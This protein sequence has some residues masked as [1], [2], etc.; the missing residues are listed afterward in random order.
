MKKEINFVD[1]FKIFDYC[2]NCL[3]RLSKEK[4]KDDPYP[5]H[6]YMSKIPNTNI[7]VSFSISI[8]K[9][10]IYLTEV[11]YS[12]PISVKDEIILLPEVKHLMKN[13]ITKGEYNE[14][15]KKMSKESVEKLIK[16]TH[17]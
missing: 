11:R 12:E 3:Y 6:V 13:R 16:F 10:R 9:C 2:L 14:I 7:E 17:E 15:L 1:L 8:K 5:L 4:K